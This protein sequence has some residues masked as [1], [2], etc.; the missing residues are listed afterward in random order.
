[1]RPAGGLANGDGCRRI[2]LAGRCYTASLSSSD[3]GSARNIVSVVGPH[4]GSG[5]TLLIAHLAR[6]ISGIGCL[7]ISC[8]YDRPGQPV[9]GPV[10]S[11]EDFSLDD[12]SH[13]GQAGKDT[14]VYLAAGAEQV[15]RLACR[16]DRLRGGLDAALAR[17]PVTMPIV[18]ESSSAARLL[19]PVAVV[20][21]ARPPIRE[22]K[23]STEAVLSRVTDLLINAPADAATAVADS[24]CLSTAF[25][26]LRPAVT[27]AADLAHEPPPR[28]MLERLAGLLHGR[29]LRG[30]A[31]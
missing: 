7:K 18:I 3:V 31:D 25:P 23:P 8:P 5:K 22:M 16:R 1:M 14:A 24:Q 11:D 27:W 12:P 29:P 17:F 19:D 26:S 15:E 20:L 6:H 10:P 30:R 28:A 21:V 13:L 9:G 4:S 2:S